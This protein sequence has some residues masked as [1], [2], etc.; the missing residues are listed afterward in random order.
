M[1]FKWKESLYKCCI[2]EQEYEKIGTD[3]F[4]VVTLVW[5]RKVSEEAHVYKHVNTTSSL[6]LLESSPFCVLSLLVTALFTQ[7]FS[8]ENP[9]I[10]IP[11]VAK[12]RPKRH[13][14]IRIPCQCENPQAKGIHH[15][16]GFSR[17]RGY[18][19]PGHFLDCFCIFLKNYNK[20]VTSKMCFL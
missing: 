9:P 16:G 1:K 13:A 6:F 18:C 10:A 19:T 20:L 4:L 15:G 2:Y 8:D 11:N 17:L 7:S 14:H 3:Y 12:E 5:L